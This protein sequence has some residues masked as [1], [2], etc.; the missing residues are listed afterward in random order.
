MRTRTVSGTIYSSGPILFIPFILSSLSVSTPDSQR[1][2]IRQDKQ[3]KQDMSNDEKRVLFILSIFPLLSHAQ[4][5]AHTNGAVAALVVAFHK[6]DLSVSHGRIE[7]AGGG[8]ALAD[9]QLDEERTRR[10]RTAF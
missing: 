5:A 8:V 1:E 4:I 6:T 3:D 2:D 9:F 10:N 7:V